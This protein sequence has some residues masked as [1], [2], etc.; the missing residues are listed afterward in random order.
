[1]TFQF[2]FVTIGLMDSE[3]RNRNILVGIVFLIVVILIVIFLIRRK[4][5]EIINVNSPLPTATTSYEQKL[6]N[7][8][9]I[10]VPTTAV[11][12]DLS[13]VS[14][15]SQMGIATKDRDNGQNVYTIIANL[16]DP[17]QGYFYQGWLV[18]GN[19][20]ESNY[21]LVNLGR[22]T[23]GKGGWIVSYSTTNDLSDHKS[24][25]VTL[26]SFSTN[27]PHQHVLEGSF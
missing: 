10:T 15:G 18:R 25:W 14:G 22:L 17:Q 2:S 8:F 7:D 24:V 13:D 23:S 9:G 11:K 26:E 3:N 16:N 6:Q 27:T 20:G 21:D 1:M 19:L 4:Q 12:T 5:P